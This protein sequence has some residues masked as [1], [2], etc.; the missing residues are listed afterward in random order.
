MAKF[1]L[2][3]LLNERSKA[4]A[5]EREKEPRRADG[6]EQL[7]LDVYDLIPSQDNFYSTQYI[8][9]LK[10]SIAIVGLL[11]PLLV[12]RDGDKY[13]VTAG[14]RRRLACIALVEDGLEQFRRVPCVIQTGEAP[15]G[16]AETILDRLALI[17]ANG[18]REKSDWEKME[19]S[20][21]TE[22]LIVE[23]RK[24]VNLEGRTRRILS[25]FTGITETQLGRYKTIKKNLCPRLMQAFKGKRLGVS[26][27]C[28]LS[29]L[30]MDYQERAADQLEE[31]GVL[32]IN[33]AKALKQEEE[34]KKPLEGQTELDAAAEMQEPPQTTQNAA[35]DAPEA[36][37]GTTTTAQAAEADKNAPEPPKDT[38]EAAPRNTVQQENK[39]PKETP[40]EPQTRP[41]ADREPRGRGCAFCHP[42]YHREQATAEGTYLLTYEPEEKTV[43]ILDK[44]TGAAEHIIFPCCP[45]CGRKLK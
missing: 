39:P 10:Q 4:A 18:F 8:D 9:D 13:R 16:T 17:F 34:A 2:H 43:L 33:D 31:M 44:S 12:K 1:D 25:E 24:E 45:F 36:A 38:P 35:K 20:L 30:S 3:D 32:S 42:D 7:T 37:G 15:Q 23:L 28:E 6:M 29:G 11:Q 27:A 19:E 14:H 41:E 5:V 22:A 21:Q 26:T 40:Q